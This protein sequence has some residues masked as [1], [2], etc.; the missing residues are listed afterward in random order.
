MAD[1]EIAVGLGGKTGVDGHALVLAALCNILIN[2]I[3]D[4]ILGHYGV[5]FLR[6]RD[7][8]LH[9]LITYSLYRHRREKATNFSRPQAAKS[10]TA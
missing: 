5:E 1:V 7:T 10:L 9:S 4:K 2:E 3:V 6:H 8:L